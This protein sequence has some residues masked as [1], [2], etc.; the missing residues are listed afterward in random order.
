[1]AYVITEECVACGTCLDVCPADAIQEGEEKYTID[2]EKCT[3]CGSCVE[4]C[5]TEAITEAIEEQ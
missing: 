4:V 1:M 2:Q 3:E 5:P